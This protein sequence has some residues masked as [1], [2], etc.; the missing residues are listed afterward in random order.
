MKFYFTVS[1]QKRLALTYALF[2]AAALGGLSL[3]INFFTSVTFNALIKE[4]ISR[5][6][7]E[8]VWVMG[9]LYNPLIRNFNGPGVE[10]LGMHFVHEGYIV[11]VEDRRGE[12]VW[13]ARSCDMEQCV[14]VINDIAFRMEQDFRLRGG[15]EKQR[16]PVLYNNRT[17]GT[18]VIE[19]YGPFFYSETETRFLQSLHRLLLIAGVV[20]ALLGAGISVPLS[21]SIAKPVRKAGEAARRI[22]QVHSIPVVPGPPPAGTDPGGLVIRINDRYKTRELRDLSRSINELAR[23]LEEGERRQRRLIAD[24]AHELRTPLTCLQGNM[25]AMIDGVYTP[26]RERLE[27][28]YEEIIRLS[29]LVAD[30]NILAS[31]EGSL[32]EPAPLNKTTF[33]LA[34]LVRAAAEQFAPGAREKGIGLR[35]DLAE[36]FVTADYDRLKQVFINLL[37]NA[38]KYTD[39]GSICIAITRAKVPGAAWDVTVADTGIGIPEK[40]LPHIF[41]RF[42]RSDKSRSRSTGGAGIGLAIA[43]AIVHAHG[44][45][46]TAESPGGEGGGA[47]FRVRL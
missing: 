31:L 15:I 11:T 36:S 27:S 23:E 44:G 32:P 8:I 21:R 3:A 33:D 14:E 25:E 4:N 24:L 6:S 22:A 41:E 12:P 20:L 34:G 30:L 10:A 19:T 2:I 40:D 39:R 9:E 47:L 26:D 13:D 35:L 29:A 37:S 45:T 1:L 17:V 28:C 38:V 18:V 43:A 46:V 16:R 5:K 7:D 42:Y